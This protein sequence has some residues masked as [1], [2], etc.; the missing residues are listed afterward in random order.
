MKLSDNFVEVLKNFADINKGVVFKPGQVLRT[1]SS[2]KAIL[3]QAELDESFESEFGIY[4]LSKLLALLS[5]NKAAPEVEVGKESLVFIGLNGK[6]KIKQRF[7]DPKLILVPPNKNINISKW[8]VKFK[9]TKEVFDWIFN[10]SSI[11]GCPN[12]VI[13]G[14]NGS[15]TVN[16]VDVKGEVVDDANVMVE[17]DTDRDF[18]AVF[19]IDNI[20]VLPGEYEVEIASAGVSRFTSTTKKLTY[21]IAIEA[22]TST[23]SKE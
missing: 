11:L 3:A 4:D 1:I 6:G 19:K 15:I 17:G 12:I 2:N 20:K 23:F 8:D 13:E 18:K 22:A 14:K 16:A 7:T 9:L 21:W 5:L 10:V